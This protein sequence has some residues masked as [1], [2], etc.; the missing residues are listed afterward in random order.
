[1]KSASVE[2]A[3]FDFGG[4]QAAPTGLGAGVN[5]HGNGRSPGVLILAPVK[6]VPDLAHWNGGPSLSF[7]G[8]GRSHLDELVAQHLSRLATDK[9]D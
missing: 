8:W 1:M 7:Q 6:F 3:G 4:N 9:L 2:L 5:A